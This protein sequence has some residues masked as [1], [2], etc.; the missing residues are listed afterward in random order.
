MH[1][2]VLPRIFGREAQTGDNDKSDSRSQGIR[3][4]RPP[5][6]M[7]DITAL[8]FRSRL[9]SRR[10]QAQF[11]RRPAAPHLGKEGAHEKN[12]RQCDSRGRVACCTG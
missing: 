5:R 6:N 12:A 3:P 2:F 8:S 7:T 1:R 9:A 10:L 11:M 4:V